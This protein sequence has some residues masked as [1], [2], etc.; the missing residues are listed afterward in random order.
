MGLIEFIM[1][2]NATA[3][4]SGGSGDDWIMSDGTWSDDLH[5]D[6]DEFWID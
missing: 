1:M 4:S 6:D 3:T 5:W 2:L